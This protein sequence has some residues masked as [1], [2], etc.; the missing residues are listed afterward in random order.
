MEIKGKVKHIGEVESFGASFTKRLL[1]VETED[2]FNNLCPIEFQKEKTALLD[3][4][5][6]GQDVTVQA[7]VG[8]R[9]YS[10][11]YYPSITGWK[12]EAQAAAP[13]RVATTPMVDNGYKSPVAP[14]L[15]DESTLPF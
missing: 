3:T 9:E 5:Q 7:N 6:I 11:K 14:F 15:E 4:L 12:I 13:S 2:K 8:G 1:V 10:G